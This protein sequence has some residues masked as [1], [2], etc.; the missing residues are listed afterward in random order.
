M[1]IAEISLD[2]FPLCQTGKCGKKVPQTILARP[3]TP[4]QTWEKSAPSHPCKPL[5]CTPTALKGNA[6]MEIIHF[7]KELPFTVEDFHPM[8]C[9]WQAEVWP[10]RYH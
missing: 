1:G 2:P 3:Y 8:Y 5:L 7:K 6:H 10:S 9:P 4:G